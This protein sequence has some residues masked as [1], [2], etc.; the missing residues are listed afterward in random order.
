MTML[1]SVA[2][3]SFMSCLLAPS[4][5][6]PSVYFFTI[7]QNTTFLYL[8]YGLC[9]WDLVLCF[10]PPRGAFVI[11]PSIACH[12]QSIPVFLLY[13]ANP[14]IHICLKTPAFLHSWN[15]SCHLCLEASRLLGRAFHYSLYVGRR[16]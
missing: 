2:L 13:I 15:L 6:T 8:I 1:C 7:Y 12:F 11:T 9:L 4:T 16:K 14:S 10:F 3:V 5:H